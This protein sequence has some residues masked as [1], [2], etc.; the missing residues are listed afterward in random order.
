MIVSLNK[1]LNYTPYR[2]NYCEGYGSIKNPGQTQNKLLLKILE[3]CITSNNNTQE[4][5]K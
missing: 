2:R 1:T 4:K 3:E 5:K